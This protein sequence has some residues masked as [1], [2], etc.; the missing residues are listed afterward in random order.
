MYV[1]SIGRRVT[2]NVGIVECAIVMQDCNDEA[3]YIP[4]YPRC[5][6]V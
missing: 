4:I 2:H 3:C 5:L 1:V 6:C